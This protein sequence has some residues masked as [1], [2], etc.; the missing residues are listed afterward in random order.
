LYLPNIRQRA[1]KVDA[2]NDEVIS[3]IDR[4]ERGTTK[5]PIMAQPYKITFLRTYSIFFHLSV[6]GRSIENKN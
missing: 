1:V 2:G 6:F 4:K 5:A 3:H